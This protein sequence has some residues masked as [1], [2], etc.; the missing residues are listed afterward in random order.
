MLQTVQHQIE[1]LLQPYLFSMND[2]QTR[3][4]V[5]QTV[6]NYMRS[7]NSSGV[8]DWHVVCD[9]SNNT[10]RDIYNGMLNLD[11]RL[12]PVGHVNYY[13]LHASLGEVTIRYDY[14]TYL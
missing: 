6:D 1:H 13:H 2:H 8:K 12:Q 14:K 7:L 4:M 11:V 9:A 5:A 3:Q 10:P